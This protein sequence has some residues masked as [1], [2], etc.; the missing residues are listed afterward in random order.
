M[1]KE[2]KITTMRVSIPIEGVILAREGSETVVYIEFKGKKYKVISEIY[3]NNFWH[4][5]TANGIS[6]EIIRSQ[7]E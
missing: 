5:I 7:N 4:S 3:D 1:S 6:E 2:K